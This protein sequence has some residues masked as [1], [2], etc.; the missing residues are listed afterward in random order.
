MFV[1]GARGGGHPGSEQQKIGE[2]KTNYWAVLSP[3]PEG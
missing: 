3:V 1:S 2:V